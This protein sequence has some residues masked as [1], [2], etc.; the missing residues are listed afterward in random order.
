MVNTSEI[1]KLDE[2]G[3]PRLQR[4]AHTSA[5]AM[6]MDGFKAEILGKVAALPR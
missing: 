5:N 6:T 3:V 4:Y 1:G 2:A